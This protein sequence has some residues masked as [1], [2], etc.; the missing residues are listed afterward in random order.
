MTFKKLKKVNQSQF[1]DWLSQNKLFTRTEKKTSDKLTY[2][3]YDGP[4]K[5]VAKIIIPF[6]DLSTVKHFIVV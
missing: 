6:H 4:E 5:L 3:Y 2:E 1:K